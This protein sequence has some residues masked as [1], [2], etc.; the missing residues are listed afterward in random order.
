MSVLRNRSDC[1]LSTVVRVLTLNLALIACGSSSEPGSASECGATPDPEC[2]SISVAG[3]TRTYLL[4]VPSSFHS[5]TGSLVV[6]LHGLG[7][8]AVDLRDGTGLNAKADK[9]GFAI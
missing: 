1:I 2:R 7:Q 5:G 9:E 6:A 8:H 3:G 4:H